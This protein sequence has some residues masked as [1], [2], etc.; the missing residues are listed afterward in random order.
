MSNPLGLACTCKA[1]KERM[2]N[3]ICLGWASK[4]LLNEKISSREK[5]WRLA[6][7]KQVLRNVKPTRKSVLTTKHF[8]HY[9]V[10][11]KADA[12]QKNYDQRARF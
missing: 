4:C 10:K 9:K 6:T 5:N 8:C 11:F 12:E 1:C 3:C 2:P 7:I